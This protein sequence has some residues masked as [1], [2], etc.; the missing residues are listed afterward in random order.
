MTYSE[1]LFP[2]DLHIVWSLMI[3]TYPYITGL[4]AG[5][6]IASSLYHLFGREELAPVSRFSLLV[7][8][9]FLLCAT[10]P[11]LFHLGHPERALNVMITPH[12]HSAIAGFGFIYTFYLIVLILEILVSYREDNIRAF[13]AS[14]GGIS[15]KFWGALTLGVL[16]V[17]AETKEADRKTIRTLTLIGVPAAC[18]LHGYV[19]F[20]F[21]SLKSNPWW[22]TPLM[23]QVFLLSAIMSGLA[24][25]ILLYLFL[26]QR[27]TLDP[28][29]ECLK[30]LNF[31][32]W[33][34]LVGY[35]VSEGLELLFF[36][37][38]SSDAWFVISTLL[39]TRLWN[40]F[41]LLQL[42]IG[43]VVSFILLSILLFKRP[44][45]TLYKYLTILASATILFEVWMMRWNI[46]VGG[47]QFSKSY[48]GFRGYTPEWF[49]KE[50]IVTAIFLTLLPLAILFALTRFFSPKPAEEINI[51]PEQPETIT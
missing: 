11:L 51:E 14:S 38:E 30:S 29:P 34:A 26:G 43:V 3:V 49:D 5:A 35:V 22:S 19:G 42:G 13:N 45:G 18:T 20:L 12:W 39:L 47:Q 2:N 15:R 24:L 36:F 50:G 27:N 16:R 1:F 9:S 6:F 28:D 17:D 44:V 25:V 7:S 48:V 33:L 8:L 40:S 31:F 37:Y 21:G 46:V 4:V 23:P 10:L 32:L 41:V